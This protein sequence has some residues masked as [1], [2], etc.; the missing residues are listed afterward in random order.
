[1]NRRSQTV[2][3][4]NIVSTVYPGSDSLADVIANTACERLAASSQLQVVSSSKL[5]NVV[6]IPG[7]STVV[8][9]A[10]I[11]EIQELLSVS[12]NLRDVQDGGTTTYISLVQMLAPKKVADRL[13]SN[14]TYGA[15]GPDTFSSFSALDLEVACYEDMPSWRQELEA[16]RRMISWA[17]ENSFDVPIEIERRIQR[18]TR[19]V[20]TGLIDDLYWPDMN[21]KALTLRSD[22]ALLN[23]ALQPPKASHSADDTP[24]AQEWE[25][26][27][28]QQRV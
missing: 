20:S 25:Q 4:R 1:M 24:R 12:R 15:L 10:C 11:D 19:A 17:D 6:P 5:R 26:T 8:V 27:S 23:G 9:A 16:L 13:K 21:G 2:S 7:T 28:R 3:L 18:L 14:L 22:F